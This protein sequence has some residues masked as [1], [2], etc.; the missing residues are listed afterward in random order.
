MLIATFLKILL[1]IY[2]YLLLK[3]LDNNIEYNY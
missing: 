1:I 2:L 3:I